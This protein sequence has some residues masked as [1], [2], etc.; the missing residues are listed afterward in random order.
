MVGDLVEADAVDRGLEADVVGIAADVVVD[1]AGEEGTEVDA[2]K[3]EDEGVVKFFVY[4][5]LAWLLK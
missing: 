1:V 4:I 2:L 3:G 5:L